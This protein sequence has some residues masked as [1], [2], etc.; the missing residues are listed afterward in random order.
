MRGAFFLNS[1]LRGAFCGIAR[2]RPA[3]GCRGRV[4]RKKR[5][6]A[7]GLTLKNSGKGHLIGVIG[8][9][10]TITGFLMAGVGHV[11]AAKASNYFVVDSSACDF[12][13]VGVF[14]GRRER[15]PGVWLADDGFG[16]VETPVPTIEEA[17]QK[18]TERDDVAIVLINQFIANK[19]RHL[20]AA[21]KA[22]VPAILEIP[23]K[24]HP[25]DPSKDSILQRVR[26]MLGSG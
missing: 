17:F 8:D 26:G 5:A 13:G 10:D 3:G 6:M 11:E 4:V 25:Y 9:E 1:F 18:M 23:S 16:A 7:P 12:G 14:V 22:P 2:K 20:V 24:E 21:Y 15:R 19:I